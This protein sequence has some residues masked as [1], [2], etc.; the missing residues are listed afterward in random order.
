[1]SKTAWFTNCWEGDYTCV[2]RPDFLSS[3]LCMYENTFDTRFVTINNIKDMKHAVM[4]ADNCVK[5]GVID[6]YFI[7]REHQADA[8]TRL[9]INQESV[10]R[11]INFTNW[12]SVAI[13]KSDCDYLVHC[14]AD[15]TFTGNRKWVH[16]ATSL[17]EASEDIIMVTPASFHSSSIER[18]QAVE[19]FDGYCLNPG[20]TDTC[21]VVKRH[22]VNDSIYNV[23]STG[24]SHFPL[25]SY[26]ACWEERLDNYVRQAGLFRAILFDVT[27]HHWGNLGSS[28]PRMSIYERVVR[29]IIR[30]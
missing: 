26:G 18:E 19:S 29:R 10:R 13:T 3:K 17:L 28:Y 23:P 6:N 30:K 21:F 24:N 1:M 14:A 8:F 22:L 20:I 16:V 5:S 12:I 25:S 2:L 9:G 11:V 4:L 15:I 7:V 27:W